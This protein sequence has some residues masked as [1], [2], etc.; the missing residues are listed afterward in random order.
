MPT[1]KGSHYN[2]GLNSRIHQSAQKDH[3]TKNSKNNIDI[4]HLRI[5][6][7]SFGSNAIATPQTA[8][9]AIDDEKSETVD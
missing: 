8:I 7:G 1:S 6:K 3:S 4:G 5:S 2:V 9:K